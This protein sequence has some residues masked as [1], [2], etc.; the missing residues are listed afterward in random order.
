M[1]AWKKIKAGSWRKSVAYRSAGVVINK[2]KEGYNV[3]AVC[4]ENH[5]GGFQTE[6]FD[7]NKTVKTKSQALRLAKS[8]MNQIDSK[9]FR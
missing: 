3:D 7:K 4:Y 9:C 2:T 1:S 8:F 5:P 6:L